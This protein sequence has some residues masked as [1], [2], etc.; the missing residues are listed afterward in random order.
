MEHDARHTQIIEKNFSN[1]PS[2]FQIHGYRIQNIFGWCPRVACVTTIAVL[3]SCPHTDCKVTRRARTEQADCG[4][5]RSVLG[6]SGLVQPPSRNGDLAACRVSSERGET[7]S[8]TEEVRAKLALD[9]AEAVGIEEEEIRL[10]QPARLSHRF[11]SATIRHYSHGWRRLRELDAEDPSILDTLPRDISEGEILSRLL[12][13]YANV[14]HLRSLSNTT[15]QNASSAVT[16]Y[17]GLRNRAASYIMRLTANAYNQ[18]HPTVP[19]TTNYKKYV[20]SGVLECSST[21][22]S[23]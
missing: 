10:A 5:V 8:P 22:T 15:F 17:L 2:I 9:W 20:R 11:A 6:H 19:R 12:S 1:P 16:H 3:F 21:V 23:Q 14:A 4:G 13:A 7:L 18:A